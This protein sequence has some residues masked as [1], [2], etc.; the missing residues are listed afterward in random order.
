MITR[1]QAN[2]RGTSYTAAD[3]ARLHALARSQGFDVE[4]ISVT[5][6]TLTPGGSGLSLHRGAGDPT[7]E[8]IFGGGAC[9]TWPVGDL[10]LAAAA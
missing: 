5:C 1:M 4:A 9:G 7:P 2:G 10:G 3:S 6:Y 8:A